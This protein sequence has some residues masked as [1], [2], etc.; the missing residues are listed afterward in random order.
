M[1][2][3]TVNDPPLAELLGSLI[4]Q[5]ASGRLDV[6]QDKRKRAFWFEGGQLSY[7]KSNLRSETVERIAERMPSLDA[8]GLAHAQVVVRIGNSVVLKDGTWS[9]TPNVVPPKREPQP[10]LP[11]LAR[12]V[13][14]KLPENT[15]SQRLVGLGNRFP[16]R[17]FESADPAALGLDPMAAELLQSMDG[18][19]PLEDV[20]EFSALE[21]GA[22]SRVVYL[23]LITGIVE[24]GEDQATMARIK[25]SIDHDSL[26]TQVHRDASA[27]SSPSSLADLFDAPIQTTPT[28][29]VSVVGSAKPARA[30]ESES[31]A[32]TLPASPKDDPELLELRA[33]LKRVEGC[34]NHFEI[35]EVHWDVGEAALRKAYFSLAQR[36]HPDRWTGSPPQ[37]SDLAADIFAKVNEAWEDLGDDEKRKAYTDRVIHGIKSEDELAMEKVRAILAAEDEFKA[38]QMMFRRGNLV[39]AHEL[40]LA[41]HLAVPEEAEFQAYYGY[42]LF[43]LNY[44]KDNEQAQLGVDL[45]KKAIDDHVKL[46]G[47]WVLM[48]L[49]Y[50]GAGNHKRSIGSFRKALEMNA[51]NVDAER[52][53]RRSLQELQRDKAKA[54]KDKE[55]KAGFF[56]RL[57]KK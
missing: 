38:G 23:A 20:L 1:Q 34:E 18:A 41:A 47:G 54:A 28:P 22:A 25:T 3:G 14:E 30:A 4:A 8:E 48:G 13:L 43:K 56:G 17:S 29:K 52:E 50:R 46:D 15:I 36:L 11:I 32:E 57:F 37:V 2:S 55:K 33:E 9:F 40:F 49:V 39:K 35:L 27:P 6:L 31:V 24:F 21:S 5:G 42:T 26:S 19:R 45:I 44:G 10:L 16:R 12:I 7:S 51:T 53:M